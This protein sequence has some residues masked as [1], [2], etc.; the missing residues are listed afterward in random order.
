MEV[1]H[2]VIYRDSMHAIFRGTTEKYIKHKFT[3][4]EWFACCE[5][6]YKIVKKEISS[7]LINSLQIG[8][9]DKLVEY[10]STNNITCNAKLYPVKSLKYLIYEL[11]QDDINTS[12][13]KIP[14]EILTNFSIIL[15]YFIVKYTV[16]LIKN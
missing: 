1:K 2:R 15:N 16:S 5:D 10:I 12:G 11:V 6:L 7:M 14:N 13:L 8:A 4:D 3:F 9:A